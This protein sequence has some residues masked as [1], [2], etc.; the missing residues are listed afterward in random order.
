M[1]LASG[2]YHAAS[3][4]W[5]SGLRRVDHAAIYV[6]IAGTFTPLVAH[7]V[8]GPSR[9]W[10]LGTVWT[11]AA[12]GVTLKLAFF[13]AL[14]EWFD[15]TLYLCMGWYGL[16]PAIPVIRA[17]RYDVLGWMFFGGLSYTAGALCELF[18]W[19]V[20]IPRVL[21]GHEAFH[22]AVI[23]GSAAFLSLILRHVVPPRSPRASE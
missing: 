9:L 23:I 19:P 4:P 15:I 12:A 17:R 20:L 8:H 3:E 7:M 6:L 13:G 5:K 22:V 18:R 2:T 10:L 14:P 11:M 16:V 21:G 1:F